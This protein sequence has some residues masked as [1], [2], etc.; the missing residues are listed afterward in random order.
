MTDHQLSFD[1]V[2]SRFR[3]GDWGFTGTR[4]GM[5]A[6]QYSWCRR[7]LDKGRPA[8]FYHGGA[9]GADTQVHSLWREMKT[10][11]QVVRVWP[12]DDKRRRLFMN[13]LSVAVEEVMDPLIRNAI[14]VEKSAFM[15]ATPH[16]QHE[17]IR[18]GT[19]ATI[20]TAAKEGVPTLIIWPNG[21]LT[22]HD[23]NVLYRVV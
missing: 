12:A 9:F 4:T 23:D 13:Q 17:I 7:L 15:L 10:S 8:K 22:L 1:A 11:G 20:R 14:I 19:W 18:S 6:V 21:K 16:T 5:S 3:Q 2:V